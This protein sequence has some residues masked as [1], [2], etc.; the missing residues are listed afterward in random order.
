MSESKSETG[1]VGESIKLC[2]LGDVMLGRL[3]D[4][5]FPTHVQ[6]AEEFEHAMKLIKYRDHSRLEETKRAG[7]KY[8]WGNM[9][10]YIL[11]AD[12]RIINLETSVTTHSEKWPNKAFNYRMHPDN[13]KILTEAS[14]EYCSLANNHTLDYKEKGLMDTLSSLQLSGIR[15][16]GAGINV[17]EA[18]KPALLLCK[19]KTIGVFSFAD[20]YS[21]W[22]ATE[23]KPGINFI[24]VEHYTAEDINRIKNFIRGSK[25]SHNIDIVVFSIHWGSNYCWIPPAKFQS[26]AHELIDCCEVDIL[27]GHSA[28][29]VQGIEIYREKPI[30]YGCGDFI[31][32][33]A[34]DPTYRND[35]GFAYFITLD[36]ASKSLQKIELV[37]SQIELFRSKKLE[38][39]TSDYL[40]LKTTM[41]ALCQKFGSNL[42]ELEN[43]TFAAQAKNT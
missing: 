28:H 38:K 5:I 21:F 31:D 35:L 37:P 23:N 25:Q 27:H 33:Y 34:V 3:V 1:K 2:L 41:T 13:L 14:I 17:K 32:D 7:Y 39:N 24:D 12:L 22:A 10:P 40:R 11:Q 9:L 42:S 19:G 26:F 43:G 20:H 18:S 4:Q 30:L 36:L 15:Y 8:P 16:A 6:D 29:H